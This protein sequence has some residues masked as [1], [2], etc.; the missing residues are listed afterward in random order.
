VL[1]RPQQG[2]VPGLQHVASVTGQIARANSQ[3]EHTGASGVSRRRPAMH[4]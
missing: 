2:A 3:G 4:F 1:L